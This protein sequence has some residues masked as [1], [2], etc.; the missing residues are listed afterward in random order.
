MPKVYDPVK[1]HE[2]YVRT[3]KLKGREKGAGK[4]SSGRAKSSGKS[5][6]AGSADR[7]KKAQ[8]R[9][10]RLKATVSKIQSAIS[11][12]EAAL[13]AKRQTAAKTEKNSDG[14][15]TAK[16]RQSA[17]EYR[18]KHKQEIA[19]KR[20]KTTSSSGGSSKSSS[21]SVSDM[22]V[23]DLRIRISK[24]KSALRDAKRLLA[25][26]TQDLGQI[27]HS[28]LLSDPTIE[29]EFARYKSEERI[30]SK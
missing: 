25:A 10:T 4:T 17:K 7:Q 6:N 29:V 28:A 20:R 16:E 14:K 11:E 26:A 18:D 24:L 8:E 21:T 2:Y 13:S 19:A 9:V 1:A 23:Q 27:R 15:T 12:A 22:G 5:A 3:R 30:P